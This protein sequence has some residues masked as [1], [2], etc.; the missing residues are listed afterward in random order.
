[1]WRRGC[2]WHWRWRWSPQRQVSCKCGLKNSRPAHAPTARTNTRWSQSTHDTCVH[3]V[4]ANTS[5]LTPF[6]SPTE[7]PPPAPLPAHLS[8]DLS[9]LLPRSDGGVASCTPSVSCFPALAS[10]VGRSA[11][12]IFAPTRDGSSVT[13]CSGVLVADAG[14]APALL[15]AHHCLMPG[16]EPGDA[17]KGRR[18]GPQTASAAAH[19]PPT[20]L[21]HAIASVPFDAWAVAFDHTVPCGSDRRPTPRRVVQG[22]ALR[23]FDAAADVALLSLPG[24]VPASFGAV[25]AGYAAPDTPPSALAVVGFPGGTPARAALAAGFDGVSASFPPPA[26]WHDRAAGTD[27]PPPTNATHWRVVY[28]GAGATDGG[29]SGG[30]AVD[31]ATGRV[32]GL[33]SGGFASCANAS[34]PDYV[35]NL[36]AAWR[37]GLSNFLGPDA[38]GSPGGRAARGPPL[39][40]SP[41]ALLVDASAASA[42]FGVFLTVPLPSD[43]DALDVVF[44]VV[45]VAGT[46]AAADPR[47]GAVVDPPRVALTR[48]HP[49]ASVTLVD[50]LPNRTLPDGV[51]RFYI[52]ATVVQ[53]GGSATPPPDEAK[54]KVVVTRSPRAGL[55]PALPPPTAGIL[56][57]LLVRSPHVATPTGKAAFRYAVPASPTPGARWDVLVCLSPSALPDAAVAVYVDGALVTL[58]GGAPPYR[59]PTGSDV[60]GCVA[61]WGLVATP[62]SL[63]DI[64]VSDASFLDV[65]LP[66]S[67]IKTLAMWPAVAPPADDGRRGPR[68][69]PPVPD[70]WG[71]AGIAGRAGSAGA[72]L[73]SAPALLRLDDGRPNATLAVWLADAAPATATVR[74]V[75]LTGGRVINVSPTTLT[76]TAANATAAATVVVTPAGGGNTLRGLTRADVVVS[77]AGSTSP[78]TESR[79]L[80][81]SDPLDVPKAGGGATLA[82]PANVT[83]FPP[84]SPAVWTLAP[85]AAAG[86]YRVRVCPKV[87]ASPHATPASTLALAW[88]DGG[89]R[90]LGTVD[91]AD[92]D[93]DACLTAP[94]A[95][96]GGA[97]SPPL[98]V[99]LVDSASVGAVLDAGNVRRVEVVPLK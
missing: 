95:R 5:L 61:L 8:F 56:P 29:S 82:A 85:A 44:D 96:L 27:V 54:L 67:S 22:T 18:T 60:P 79:V 4:E 55:A 23:F 16:V 1:M 6:L 43:A 75:P 25:D 47:A 26:Y 62:A 15:T 71:A 17:A 69:P 74:V 94:R 9:R 89:G 38:A 7:A 70:K 42:P 58:T 68:V 28:D 51:A 63:V 36:A 86:L 66:A 32:V 99:A 37:A 81:S 30:P 57:P 72:A 59:P 34:A 50:R 76:W 39:G 31:A 84:A 19:H 13:T 2:R 65:V 78:P 41:A 46:P 64:V 10:A 77:L 73:T 88:V 11:V 52:V 24:G 92:A 83:S 20:N 93:A 14:G 87:D 98:A 48:H 12:A 53:R 45:P 40:F 49:S 90:I 3:D 91:G 97:G 80:L 21:T 35:G 33:L